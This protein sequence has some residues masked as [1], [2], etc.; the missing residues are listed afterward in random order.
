M[1]PFARKEERA[2]FEEIL[3]QSG[4]LTSVVSKHQALNIP[5]LTAC[6]ELISTTVAS[7]P[8]K[9]VFRNR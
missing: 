4:L 5:A 8:V 7:L 1:W 9:A 2:S 6:L 3:L